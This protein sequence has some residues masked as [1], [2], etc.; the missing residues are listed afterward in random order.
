MH[1][2]LDQSSSSVLLSFIKRS[3]GS[4]IIS[5][6]DHSN[7]IVSL[8][9]KIS[10]CMP[11]FYQIVTSQI[12]LAEPLGSLAFKM[13]QVRQLVEDQQEGSTRRFDVCNP[14]TDTRSPSL[15]P[16]E[17]LAILNQQQAVAAAV[18]NT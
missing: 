5:S 15:A 1:H 8:Y 10:R 11:A 7:D 14:S 3:A 17:L 4:L 2:Q 13:V 16:G 18:Y 9:I 6:A 12:L